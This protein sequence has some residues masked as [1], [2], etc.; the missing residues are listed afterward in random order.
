MDTQ[1]ELT[2]LKGAKK[3]KA[4]GLG[5]SSSGTGSGAGGN[6]EETDMLEI[7]LGMLRCSVCKD[8][9]KSCAITRYYTTGTIVLIQ[10]LDLVLIWPILH[11]LVADLIPISYAIFFVF[12]CL[13]AFIYS[14]RNALMRICATGRAS[15]P[16]AE[17][18]LARTTSHRCTSI[19]WIC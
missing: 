17:R 5:G 1:R 16:L 7:T 3:D 15:V 13:G 19:N 6:A 14:A 2:K 8:R 4:A 18:N 10:Y 9:F 11:F 12:S